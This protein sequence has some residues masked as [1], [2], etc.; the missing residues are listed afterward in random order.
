[1]PV[2]INFKICD[3]SED[4]SGITACPAHAF[5][6]DAKRRTIA[7]DQAK[8][9]AC[10]ACER[11]CP[12][13]AIRVAR[14]EI[15]RQRLQREMDDDP[16]RVTDLFVDRYGAQ[17]I[18]S[19]FLIPESK[20]DVQIIRSTKPAVVELFSRDSVQCM[21]KSIPVKELLQGDIKYRKIENVALAKKYRIRAL[22]AL[23]F[24]SNGK[25]ID[26]IEGYY[27]DGKKEELKR[28]IEVILSAAKNL[29]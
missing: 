25:L 29:K 6:W 10:G 3:N 20:F 19:A 13:G 9:R 4:C 12:V 5:A 18:S 27:G 21:I 22:P 1:M 15:E 23:L 14:S 26:K 17:P 24:F 2:L 28:R 7:V 8:C 16:R 11:A